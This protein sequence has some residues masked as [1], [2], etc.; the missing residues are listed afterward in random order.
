MEINM[1]KIVIVTGA[2]SGMGEEYVLQ[3]QKLYKHLDEIWVIARRKERLDK[4]AEKSSVKL[5]PLVMDLQKSE[6]YKI[7]STKLK[8]EKPHILMLVNSA[9]FGVHGYFEEQ[10]EKEVLGMVELNCHAV[11]KVTHICIPYMHTN[12]RIINMA[13][14]A[15]FFPQK[16]F[17]VYAATKSYV[18]SF[19]RSLN[20]ELKNRKIYVTAVCP[21]PVNTEFFKKDNCDINKTFYKRMVMAEA[22][23]VVNLALKDSV[24]K[25]ELSIYGNLMKGFYVFTKLVPHRIML[26]FSNYIL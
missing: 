3:I 24:H 6:D 17:S 18:L 15:A 21:G 9:G 4:L 7:L 5:V 23:D 22:K 11:T 26:F 13:S 20:V 12:S 16:R 10:E 2:S 8:E 25:K 1:K 14:A 19:S